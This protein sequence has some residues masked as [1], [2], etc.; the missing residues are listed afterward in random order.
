MGELVGR[1][2]G[3]GAYSFLGHMVD[4]AALPPDDDVRS[5]IQFVRN[6]SEKE[7]LLVLREQQKFKLGF[8]RVMA[9]VN[10]LLTPTTAALLIEQVNQS[11]TAK[12]FTWPA[13]LV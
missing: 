13:N 6:M 8:E 2:I 4:D 7:Y 10:A 12:H 5:R 1:I 11:G 9:D 3:T